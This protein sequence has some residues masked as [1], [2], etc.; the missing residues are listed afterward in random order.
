M[1]YFNK[2]RDTLFLNNS[3]YLKFEMQRTIKGSHSDIHPQNKSSIIMQSQSPTSLLGVA[4]Y[5]SVYLTKIDRSLREN[6][7]IQG[8]DNDRG[9]KKGSKGDS[10]IEFMF[11]RSTLYRLIHFSGKYFVLLLSYVVFSLLTA[12][13]RVKTPYFAGKIV[14]AVTITKSEDQITLFIHDFLKNVLISIVFH[15]LSS[16]SEFFLRERIHLKLKR[17][18]YASLV[19][20]DTE[21]MEGKGTTKILA[22]LD[23]DIQLVSKQAT[24]ITFVEI[25]KEVYTN[26]TRLLQLFEISFGMTMCL[27]ITFPLFSVVIRRYSTYIKKSTIKIDKNA[28]ECSK[29]FTQTVNNFNLIKSNSQEAEFISRFDA[30]LDQSRELSTTRSLL[31]ASLQ[32]FNSFIQRLGEVFILMYGAKLLLSNEITPGNFSTFVMNCSAFA[33]IT[34]I[35]S[36]HMNSISKAGISCQRFFEFVDYKVKVHWNTGKV[37]E[38]IDGKISF[39]GV[40]FAYPTRPEV[41]VIKNASFEVE[42]KGSIGIVG[43]SGSGKS[44][45][46]KI[47][48]RVFD[49]TKGVVKIDGVNLKE[50]NLKWFHE[51]VGYVNPDSVLFSGTLE[52]N[53]AFGVKNYTHEDLM[54]CIKLANAKDIIK[55]FSKGLETRIGEKGMKLSSGQRQK[56]LIARALLRKPKI[57]IFDEATAMLDPKSEYQIQMTINKL[58]EEKECTVVIIGNKLSAVRKC[59]MILAVKNGEIV[60]RGTHKELMSAH[61]FYKKMYEN[62]FRAQN[63]YAAENSTDG[64]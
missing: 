51:H 39:E 41:P 64:V 22:T 44:S 54:R 61:G 35:F 24:F 60:E 25:A 34:K 27:L 16:L 6:P 53:I 18:A 32:V 57:L 2:I 59:D 21:Y 45:F 23:K 58:I 38:K 14:D 12:V 33:N 31:D 15:F 26:S 46:M 1:V 10:N 17:L 13:Y 9:R 29:I 52:E 37:L 7:K 49:P 48:S 40:T 43:P 3:N 5:S 20:K 8:K 42:A 36:E 47:I 50:L 19:N 63:S 62:Q 11:R 56:I 30:I 4:S 55:G 28:K